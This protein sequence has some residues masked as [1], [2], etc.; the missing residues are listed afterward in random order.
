[1][2]TTTTQPQILTVN[3]QD[4]ESLKDALHYFSSLNDNDTVTIRM[5]LTGKVKFEINNIQMQLKYPIMNTSYETR[6]TAY[7]NRYP[8][9]LENLNGSY[10]NMLVE[11]PMGFIVQEDSTQIHDDAIKDKFDNFGYLQDHNVIEQDKHNYPVRTSY[12]HKMMTTQLYRYLVTVGAMPIYK[13]DTSWVGTEQVINGNIVSKMMFRTY[14]KYKRMTVREGKNYYQNALQG[15]PYNVEDLEESGVY[16]STIVVMQT[17]PMYVPFIQDNMFYTY[18]NSKHRYLYLYDC[19]AE[20]VDLNK[21]YYYSVHYDKMNSTPSGKFTYVIKEN[22]LGEATMAEQVEQQANTLHI[23]EIGIFSFFS[24]KR[25]VTPAEKFEVMVQFFELF[26]METN[27]NQLSNPLTEDDDYISRE[28]HLLPLQQYHKF[29]HIDQPHNTNTSD[30]EGY[31]I[32]TEDQPSRPTSPERGRYYLRS[33][34]SYAQVMGKNTIQKPLPMS[35]Q[36]A[37]T[38][39]PSSYHNAVQQSVQRN[40]SVQSNQEPVYTNSRNSG[41]R[42]SPRQ[43]QQRKSYRFGYGPAQQ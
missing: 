17:M 38:G 25:L 36:V 20:W 29:K 18:P 12:Y 43:T 6:Q 26:G 32:M 30:N 9:L 37:R 35:Q 2:S 13:S 1:M 22:K 27:V 34:V 4:M 19:I 42:G 28:N 5:S 24:H 11:T 40:Q 39:S 33:N 14:Y 8:Q 15:F 41:R 3:E 31:H 16:M 7:F 10:G 21:R 23:Y